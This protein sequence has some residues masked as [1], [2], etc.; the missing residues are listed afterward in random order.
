M[1]L[2]NGY[3]SITKLSG[4]RRKPYNVR[5]TIGTK[6]IEQADGTIEYRQDRISIGCFK[7]KT[8]ALKAL[9]EYNS[10]P[11]NLNDKNMTFSEIYECWKKINYDK[12]KTSA[13]N[14]RDTAYKY[15]ERLYDIPL[16]NIKLE[17]LQQVVDAC[18]HGSS[19]KKNI[20]TAI[21]TVYTTAI[22]NEIL[23]KDLSEYIVIESSDPII[24]RIPFSDDEISLLWQ[25][26]D[27][28]D[29]S[30]I[31]IL[32]YSGMR[33]NELLKNTKANVNLEER[34]IYVPEE[35]AKNKSSIRYVPIHDKIY[36]LVKSF[37]DRAT[38]NLI[39]N[40]SGYSVTYNNFVAR[41]LKKINATLE[42]THRFH[43][44]RHTFISKCHYAKL[45]ELTVKKIVG[46]TP[47]GI[48]AKVYT[49]IDFKSM[50]EEINKLDF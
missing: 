41:N 45:D 17:Q 2:P 50:Y 30:I 44:T 36:P 27:K 20:K 28:F 7:T 4:K 19:T 6:A 15:C 34:W 16:R 18:E 3:G 42:S 13:K 31:L 35:L 43:D 22:K 23:H 33:V 9:E 10:D 39:T 21:K 8:E 37:Y 12:L 40:D 47:E 26:S 24:D 38:T 1:K 25:H 5:V 29:Y 48:T 49:H 32:L 14:S 46:H 11:Y